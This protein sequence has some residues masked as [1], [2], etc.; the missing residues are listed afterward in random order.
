MEPALFDGLV[1]YDSPVR[2]SGEERL[3]LCLA[4]IYNPPLLVTFSSQ[5][6]ILRSIISLLMP[7]NLHHV[8][9]PASRQ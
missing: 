7:C 1:N 6:A 3:H 2:G 4:D 8:I 9:I 5:R